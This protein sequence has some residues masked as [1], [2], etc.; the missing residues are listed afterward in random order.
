V[1]VAPLSARKRK[2]SS[3]SRK[4][5]SCLLA[6]SVLRSARCL[7][8]RNDEVST[9]TKTPSTTK[10]ARSS[11]SGPKVVNETFGSRKK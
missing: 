2:R 1:S 4:P 8:D 6:S 11:N 5:S 7:A 10:A 3:L 9:L